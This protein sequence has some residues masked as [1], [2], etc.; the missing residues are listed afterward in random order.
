MF[1]S[2]SIVAL[3]GNVWQLM[4]GVNQPNT[5]ERFCSLDIRCCYVGALDLCVRQFYFINF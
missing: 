2:S 5:F 4:A 1:N 3:A